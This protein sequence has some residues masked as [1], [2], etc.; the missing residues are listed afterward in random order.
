MHKLV[1][2]SNTKIAVGEGSGSCITSTEKGK[3]IKLVA[4]SITMGHLES[5]RLTLSTNTNM[6]CQPLQGNGIVFI[7]GMRGILDNKFCL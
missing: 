5:F 4:G 2:E 6:A 3:A 7:K 1:P